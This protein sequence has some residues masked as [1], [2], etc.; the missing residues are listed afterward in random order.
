LVAAYGIGWLPRWPWL[1][2][3][4][5]LTR[6]HWSWIATVLIGLGHVAWIAL[7]L[8]YLPEPSALQV[9]YGAVGV[10]L[11]LLPMHPAVRDYLAVP[12]SS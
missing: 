9:V 7:E 3:V 12:S 11:L 2:H 8:I 5:R 6:H 4:Q 10:A 1:D